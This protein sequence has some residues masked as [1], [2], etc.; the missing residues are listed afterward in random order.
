[1]QARKIARELREPRES[2]EPGKIE[3]P[4]KVEEP[5]KVEIATQVKEPQTREP[6]GSKK[7]PR[8]VCRLP[9]RGTWTKIP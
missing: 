8:S 5:D 3:E 1:M 7:K 9:Q 6:W 2:G 4:A